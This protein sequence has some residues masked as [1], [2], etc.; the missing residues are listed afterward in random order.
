MK[1]GLKQPPGCTSQVH[2]TVG[3]QV[4]DPLIWLEHIT[5]SYNW[6]K[7]KENWPPWQK[8][9]RQFWR[10]K[11]C[12][13]GIGLELVTKIKWNTLCHDFILKILRS[14]KYKHFFP[15]RLEQRVSFYSLQIRLFLNLHIYLLTSSQQCPLHTWSRFKKCAIQYSQCWHD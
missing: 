1:L 8:R 12:L 6:P 11:C 5:F 14:Y 2:I 13:L 9:L 15:F 3:T 7:M 10:R 4:L